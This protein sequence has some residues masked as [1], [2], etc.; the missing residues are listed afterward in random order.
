MNVS[1]LCQNRNHEIYL[2]VPQ[3]TRGDP[4]VV[5]ISSLFLSYAAV[6]VKQ[7]R[8]NQNQIFNNQEIYW[9]ERKYIC[10]FLYYLIK[11]GEQCAKW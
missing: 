6:T 10:R 4:R 9:F 8:W 3:Y 11:R 1:N 2:T 5:R 7:I